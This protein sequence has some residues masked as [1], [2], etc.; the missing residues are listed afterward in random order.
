MGAFDEQFIKGYA[1]AL[2]TTVVVFR[3]FTALLWAIAATP[4]VVA[5]PTV[6]RLG[7]H[8]FTWATSFWRR[9]RFGILLH[10]NVLGNSLSVG[11]TGSLGWWL[12]LGCGVCETERAYRDGCFRQLN[13]RTYMFRRSNIFYVSA[14]S[15]PGIVYY[16]ALVQYGLLT[17]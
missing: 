15:W 3:L 17:L 11:S 7:I 12:R 13:P 8:G 4:V 14:F 16:A 5:T 1:L 10:G 9:S 2:V 6:G